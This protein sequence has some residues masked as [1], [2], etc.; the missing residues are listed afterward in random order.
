MLRIELQNFA[1]V[2]LRFI[3]R[4]NSVTEFFDRVFARVVAGERQLEIPVE[5][6]QQVLEITCA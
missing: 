3:E 1:H 2:T 5:T 4:R 6:Y